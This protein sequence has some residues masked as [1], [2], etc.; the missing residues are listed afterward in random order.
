MNKKIDTLWGNVIDNLHKEEE[1][2]VFS[3]LKKKISLDC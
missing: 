2:K 3:K 1:K